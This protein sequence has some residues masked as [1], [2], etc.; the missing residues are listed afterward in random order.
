MHTFNNFTF[1]QG[2]MSFYFSYITTLSTRRFHHFTHEQFH[3]KN[4]TTHYTNH[5]I[6]YHQVGKRYYSRHIWNMDFFTIKCIMKGNHKSS[7]TLM[8]LHK[9]KLGKLLTS[10]LTRS[11]RKMRS[12]SDI[13]SASASQVEF[14]QDDSS[15]EPLWKLIPYSSQLIHLPV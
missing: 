8:T 1:L 2:R 4:H 3:K 11:E 15:K 14:P 12:V 5:V 13:I 10:T 7:N 9:Q 6:K